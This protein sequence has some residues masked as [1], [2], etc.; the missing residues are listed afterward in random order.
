MVIEYTRSETH[1]NPR[2]SHE[3]FTLMVTA[4]TKDVFWVGVND[5]GTELFEALWP[6]PH[7]ISYN[8]YLVRD[9]KT[10]LIDTV[11]KDYGDAFLREIR[12]VLSDGHKIDYLVINHIEPDHSGAI[13]F[14][15]RHF[16]EMI[17]VGNEKTAGLL[18]GFYK[19]PNQTLV[20]K[21]Q[22]TLCLGDHTLQFVLTPMVHWPETMMTYEQKTQTL[23]SGDVFGGFGMLQNGIFD[24]EADLDLCAEETR[25]Y[26]SNVIGKYSGMVQKAF[27]K[28]AALPI[29]IL[30]PTHGPV[31]RKDPK[32]IMDLYSKWSRYETEKGV[33]I[34]YASMY[35]HTKIMAE[36]VARGLSENGLQEIK[37]YDVS[38]TH[39]SFIINDIWRCRGLVLGSCTYN[40]MLF[41]MMELLL[42]T[43]DNYHIQNHTLGLFGSYSWGGGALSALKK[44]AEKGA[45]KVIEPLPEAK[46]APA[47]EVLAQ[48]YLLGKNLAATLS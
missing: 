26:F 20:I 47:D 11:K 23:F 8:A 25:R 19:V 37:I 46:C 35:G 44:F 16:P 3:R 4:V 17:I 32:R 22:D 2:G 6:L 27:A 43:L 21:D 5:S 38:H 34:V 36:T 41:P 18:N 24:D 28:L 42:S 15:T 40:T 9:K 33:V 1:G 31:Y 10:A 39:M 12:S 29:N 7:G 48:C 13:D 45:W 30:A 14:L